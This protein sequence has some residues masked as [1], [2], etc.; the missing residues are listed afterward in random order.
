VPHQL[1]EV[2]PSIVDYIPALFLEQDSPHFRVARAMSLLIV[3][4]L[5]VTVF[6]LV[7]HFRFKVAAYVKKSS[8]KPAP[9]A[10]DS[11]APRADMRGRK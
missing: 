2:L 10:A 4:A 8:G 6:A 5:L 11:I 3:I 1:S 7:G 9:G